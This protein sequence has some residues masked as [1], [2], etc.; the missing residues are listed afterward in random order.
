MCR[1]TFD[2]TCNQQTRHRER[3]CQGLAALRKYELSA[4]PLAHARMADNVLVLDIVNAGS[5]FVKEKL[6]LRAIAP[7]RYDRQMSL[8]TSLSPLLKCHDTA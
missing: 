8:A 3:Y 5:N 4:L 2:F 6:V 1:S 7:M